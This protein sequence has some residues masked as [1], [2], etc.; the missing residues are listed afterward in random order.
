MRIAGWLQRARQSNMKPIDN[1]SI[2]LTA[3]P[4]WNPSQDRLLRPVIGRK[5][6]CSATVSGFELASK[7]CA[8]RLKSG[9][10]TYAVTH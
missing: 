10:F 1:G 9:Y 3:M 5:L 2:T 7:G 6:D 4:G 8:N